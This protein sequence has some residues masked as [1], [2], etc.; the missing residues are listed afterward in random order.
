MAEERI[1]IENTP[2]E[3]RETPSIS[4]AE[5]QELKGR[6]EKL[7]SQLN[8]EKAGQDKEKLV[9]QEIKSYIR[10]IQ[11]LP[12]PVTPLATRD[13]AKEIKKFEPDQQ[14][15]AL[16]SLALEKGL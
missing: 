13:E 10:E 16:I 3:S 15:G 12:V 7:E 8:R 9:K 5:V 4:E 11:Q 14:V 2:V 1:P 6:L